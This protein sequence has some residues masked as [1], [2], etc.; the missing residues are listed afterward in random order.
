MNSHSPSQPR[1]SSRVYRRA[2]S[3][4]G[5]DLDTYTGP[6]RFEPETSGATWALPTADITVPHEEW[7][8][9]GCPE[10]IRVVIERA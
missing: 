6:V 9:G 3:P 8:L 10:R 7:E 2:G 5:I 4:P 1:I